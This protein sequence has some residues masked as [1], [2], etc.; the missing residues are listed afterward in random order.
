MGSNLSTVTSDTLPTFNDHQTPLETQD[1][2]KA[3]PAVSPPG[4]A[5]EPP[6]LIPPYETH[7]SNVPQDEIHKPPAASP[8]LI[9][10][11]GGRPTTKALGLIEESFAQIQG[12]IEGL[13]EAI[14]KP[15]SDLYCRLERSRKGPSESHLWNIYLHYFARHEHEEAARTGKPLERSQ[16]YRSLCYAQ[17]KADHRN[18]QELLETYHELEMAAIEMTVGQ[19]KREVEKYEKKLQDMVS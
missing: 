2:N 12:I 1:H 11:T 5:P 15:P 4:E 3:T 17:Y 18:Y 6:A 8:K 16:A 9:G 7:K 10:G 14:G 13:A 19:R